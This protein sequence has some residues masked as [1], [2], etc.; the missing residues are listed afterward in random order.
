M[1]YYGTIMAVWPPGSQQNLNSYQYE[2][3]VVVSGSNNCQIPLNHVL[4]MDDFGT[5][6]DYNDKVAMVGQKV[7]VMCFRNNLSQAMIVGAIR[8]TTD[9]TDPL[10]GR[11][12]K[13]RFNTIEEWIDKDGNWSVTSD[14]EQTIQLNQDFILLDDAKGESIKI[15]K[16]SKTISVNAGADWTMQ[17]GGNCTINCEKDA[18]IKAGGNISATAAGDATVTAGGTATVEGSS[19]KLGKGAMEAVIKGRTFAAL[20]NSHVHTGNLGFP[21]SPPMTPMDPA[22]SMKVTT[23]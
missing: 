9:V 15:D 1:L 6:D 14:N 22:L 21:V 13:R 7:C 20:Y 8:N 19:V 12:W 18:T 10:A 4:M 23:E 3:S 16:L 17:L 5:A 11:F 2:Y